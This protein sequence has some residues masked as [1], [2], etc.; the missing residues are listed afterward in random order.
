[1]ARISQRDAASPA[2]CGRVQFDSQSH[3]DLRTHLNLAAREARGTQCEASAI[4]IIGSFGCA[5]RIQ[6]I[7]LSNGCD[8]E[9]G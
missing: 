8:G 3:D 4:S 6:G 1:M 5:K 7:M 9:I 2:A